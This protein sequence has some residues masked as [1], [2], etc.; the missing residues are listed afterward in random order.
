MR[1]DKPIYTLDSET[2]PFKEGRK[3]EPFAWG[4]Y[5]GL[6]YWDF[7]GDDSTARVIAKLKELP[8][9]I[10]YLHNGGKFDI[11]FLFHAIS[12]EHDMLIIK[13][14]ITQ[15]YM[16]AQ[17]GEFHRVR[18]SYK[19]LPFPLSAF[20]KDEI[21][22][23]LMEREVREQHKDK[24][25]D[26]LRKDC[27][28]LWQ[29]CSEYIKTFGPALTIGGTAM[30][31]LTKRH[32]VGEDFT[33][34]NDARI[35]KAY[36]IGGRV[37]RYK[38]G[39]FEGDW[40]VYDVNS[41]Y[42]YVMS[43]FYHPIGNPSYYGTIINKDT[44]FVTARGRNRGAFASRD[45]YGVTFGNE[46]GEFSVTIHEWNAALELGLFDCEE[47]LET[48]DFE[49][50]RMFYDYVHHYYNLRRSLKD[51]LKSHLYTCKTCDNKNE[52]YCRAATLLIIYILFYKFLLNNSYGRFAVNPENFKEYRLTPDD[53]DLRWQGYEAAQL[54]AD[55]NLILWERPTEEFHYANVATGA[56]ITGAARSVLLRGLQCAT[57]PVYCDTDCIICEGLEGMPLHPSELGAWD[58]EKQGNLLAIAGR[59]LY[60][61]WDDD[62]CIK[63]AS[64]GVNL[65]P[66]EI[67]RIA[68]GEI[69]T[70]TRDAPTFR[71]S[72]LVD[73]ITRKVRRT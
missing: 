7:W 58:L 5:N 15:C 31:E 45:D 55:F 49:H 65:T 46:Y 59:K 19:I 12:T 37:E 54:L 27:L 10:V 73:W 64:K 26:Y 41:M 34:E 8:A 14:R 51:E 16:A 30:K 23:D 50:S 57:N 35:R 9:G 25:L 69:V 63:Q 6:E 70:Y 36:Y 71:L 24:I 11:Y 44:Y 18:D 38:V 72:G 66:E 43:A 29:L 3:P 42:P 56:S 68:Q 13:E 61:L 47:I 2:D 1:Y 33:A 67:K 28:Y 60:A 39:V 20:A 52:V 62:T 48:V 32:D 53:E 17:W 21:D 22:Y 4:L 40:K